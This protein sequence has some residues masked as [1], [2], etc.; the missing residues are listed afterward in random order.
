MSSSYWLVC[1]FGIL[2]TC[3]SVN[4]WAV[5]ARFSTEESWRADNHCLKVREL[6]RFISSAKGPLRTLHIH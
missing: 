4:D 6:E 5:S 2:L 3:I 1:V